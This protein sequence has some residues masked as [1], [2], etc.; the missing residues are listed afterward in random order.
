MALTLNPGDDKYASVTFLHEATCLTGEIVAVERMSA[1]RME[2]VHDD[3]VATAFE[4]TPLD[5]QGTNLVVL[6]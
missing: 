6:R 4:L 2:F 1:L 5:L 3:G